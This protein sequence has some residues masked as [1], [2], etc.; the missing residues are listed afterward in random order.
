MSGA[1]LSDEQRVDWLRLIRS[2]N[3]GPRTFRQLINRYGGARAALEA[4]P[5]LAAKTLRGKTIRIASRDDVLREIDAATK[6]GVAYV[7]SGE[8]DYPA[9][10]REIADAPPVLSVRGRVEIL[11]RDA[12]AL[13]GSRNA[14][15]AGLAFA[16]RLA[17]GLARADHVVASG[18]AR[19]IDAVA[20]R[21]TI[22]TGTI[23]V[24][25]GGQARPY[26]AEHATLV[27]E[28]AE[29]GLLVS[30]MPLEWEPRGRD[31]PRRNR[32]I[33]G[34]SRATVVVEAAR[35]SGSL[36]TAKF[37][38]EQGREVF[39]VPGSPLD[40]RAEGTND[41]LRQGATLCTRP[42][43][44]IDALASGGPKPGGAL[45]DD[46]VA[47]EEA[48]FDELDLFAEPGAFEESAPAKA[49]GYA[50]PVEEEAIPPPVRIDARARILELLGPSP[51]P[52]D[53][54]IRMAGLP[55]RDVQGALA[56]LDLDGRLERNGP[57]AVSLLV[58]P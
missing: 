45:F 32:I 24:L 17:R 29:K 37:A 14:S 10:L 58:S 40:P 46:Q 23:A 27:E 57:N 20:H 36:I 11:A 12:V 21:A 13:V 8:P 5:E 41:L 50:P 26:P 34:L 48:L 42:E 9:L 54:L 22:D 2:E 47:I 52:I 19:G 1:R 18:L 6:M 25:A 30:E 39:A 51:V 16:E 31:F 55:A 33:S 15:S 49:F 53:T 7:A 35:R 4:L 56:E 44:V 38:N 28:L 3:I 43:D